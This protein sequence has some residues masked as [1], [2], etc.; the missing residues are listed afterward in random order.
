MFKPEDRLIYRFEDRKGKRAI[1]PMAAYDTFLEEIADDTPDELFRAEAAASRP[2]DWPDDIPYQPDNKIVLQEARR[3]RRKLLAA[4]RK[5]VGVTSVEDDPEFG[6]T[7]FDTFRLWF[8]MIDYMNSLKKNSGVTP[9]SA[10]DTA[11]PGN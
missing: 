11:S 2:P 6:L 1:D 3:A 4:I 10:T 7:E 5:A 8:D 9:S